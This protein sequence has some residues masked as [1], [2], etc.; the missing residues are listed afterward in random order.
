LGV[1]DRRQCQVPDRP[2]A[3]PTFVSRLRDHLLGSRGRIETRQLGQP[4][5]A[6]KPVTGL[7]PAL[8]VAE[9][10]DE[11][12]RIGLAEPERT[13]PLPRIAQDRTGNGLKACRAA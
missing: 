6:R 3:V 13:Q 12:R 5:D 9:V 8:G 1:A 11:R 2:A 4:V 7:A 10:G